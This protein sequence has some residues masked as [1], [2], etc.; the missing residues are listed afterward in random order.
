MDDCID[1]S[2]W[3][4]LLNGHG[5]FNF[6]QMARRARQNDVTGR[7]RPAGRRL[8]D[9]GINSQE[10]KQDL[11]TFSVLRKL[12]IQYVVSKNSVKSISDE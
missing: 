12:T 5:I 10:L 7:I 1:N 3:L 8:P 9:G 2:T 11:C 6:T 4:N